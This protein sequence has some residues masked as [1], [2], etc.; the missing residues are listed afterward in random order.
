MKIFPTNETSRISDARSTG[1]EPSVKKNGKGKKHAAAAAVAEK[2]PVSE[3]EIRE[4]LAAHVE[5]SNTAKAV[6]KQKN[7]QQLGSGFMNADMK[8][9]MKPVPAKAEAGPVEG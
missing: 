7:S 2:K 3:N 5:T 1:D 6:V 4:K 9:E 8:P